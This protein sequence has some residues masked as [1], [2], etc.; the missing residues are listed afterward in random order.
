ME[1]QWA[2][3]TPLAFLALHRACDTGR[4]RWG[5]AVG[6]CVALQMLSSIYYGIFLATMVAIATLLLVPRDRSAPLRDVVKALAAGAVLAAVV[7]GLYAIPYLRTQ[8]RVGDRPIGEVALYSAMP[9]NYLAATPGN[10][11]YRGT[12]SRGRARTAPLPRC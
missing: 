10:W 9:A 6:A 4:L 3:W 8:E 2:V 12:A 5:I 7:C 1:L 11:L